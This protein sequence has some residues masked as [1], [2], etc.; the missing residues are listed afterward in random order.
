MPPGFSLGELREDS[1]TH[2]HG[3]QAEACLRVEVKL[4]SI[5]FEVPGHCKS[6]NWKTQKGNQNSA[7]HGE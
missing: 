6:R 2:C 7:A 3:K 4:M 1:V 5:E